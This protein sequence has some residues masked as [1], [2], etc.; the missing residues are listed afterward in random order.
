MRMLLVGSEAE[1]GPMHGVA[2][3]LQGIWGQ[4]QAVLLAD[5]KRQ[6][7]TTALHHKT[8]TTSLNGKY[9]SLALTRGKRLNMSSS[10]SSIDNATATVCL[11]V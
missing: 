3:M 4:D 2:A 6:S 10:N 5:H 1:P 9:Q 11:L 7:Q 8:N